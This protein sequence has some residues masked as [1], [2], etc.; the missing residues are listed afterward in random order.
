MRTVRQPHPH[1]YRDTAL[2]AAALIAIWFP[3]GLAGCGTPS[4]SNDAAPEAQSDVIRRQDTADAVHPGRPDRADAHRTLRASLTLR[5]HK[6]GPSFP[7]ATAE[8]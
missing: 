5:S 4:A 3:L 7:I 6:R 1:G 2:F 8:D